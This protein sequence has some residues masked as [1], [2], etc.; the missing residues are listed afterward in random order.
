MISSHA[1]KIFY[2]N[3]MH[4]T[5]STLRKCHLNSTQ[6]SFTFICGQWSFSE[7]S[8]VV[9]FS[10]SSHHTIASLA[11]VGQDLQRQHDDVDTRTL[12]HSSAEQPVSGLC[13]TQCLTWCA[14]PQR[15][16][17]K[18]RRRR[19]DSC[20]PPAWMEPGCGSRREARRIPHLRLS[21]PGKEYSLHRFYN[22]LYIRLCALFWFIRQ[23]KM[24]T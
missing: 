21:S 6:V 24:S 5:D 23:K 1:F 3:L 10:S 19:H 7:T 8:N 12:R 15:R 22:R 13:Q 17:W 2:H 16:C 14:A 9:K 18:A 20:D 11:A 4:W